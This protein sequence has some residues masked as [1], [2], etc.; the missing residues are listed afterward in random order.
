MVE[1]PSGWA[2]PLGSRAT[3]SFASASR[4][5]SA[6]ADFEI[7]SRADLS[8]EDRLGIPA[9]LRRP[10][11]SS[12]AKAV[13]PDQPWLHRLEALLTAPALDMAA[14]IAALCAGLGELEETLGDRAADWVT[15]GRELIALL[16]GGSLKGLRPRL[17]DW[18]RR[19]DW[20]LQ[21]A[22]QN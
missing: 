15:E 17:N 20:L 1:P 19:V 16:E 21:P 7:M 10:A 5:V 9:F 14:M 2:M 8:L 12:A 13:A 6:D 18:L 4:G 22:S 3:P 11:L